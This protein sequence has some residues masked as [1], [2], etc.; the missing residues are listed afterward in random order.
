[1]TLIFSGGMQDYNYLAAGVFEITLE[2][3]C[4]KYPNGSELS[5]FWEYNRDPLINFLLEVHR[6]ILTYGY[7]SL[8]LMSVFSK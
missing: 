1:M 6:G 3:S 8:A 7:V 2:L 4:C 5:R